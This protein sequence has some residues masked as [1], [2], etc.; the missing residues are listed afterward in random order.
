MHIWWSISFFF[1]HVSIVR[2]I[3]SVSVLY[4]SSIQSFINLAR[5]SHS[6]HNRIFPQLSFY[7]SV[8]ADYPLVS[9]FLQPPFSQY[10]FCN[11]D[12]HKFVSVVLVSQLYFRKSPFRNCFSTFA[13]P[14]S[15]FRNCRLQIAGLQFWVFKNGLPQT[16]ACNGPFHN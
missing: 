4:C 12:F 14:Q 8:F 2:P 1:P 11:T 15:F 9:S 16:C 10:C 7:N 5:W 13:F 3:F 6:F